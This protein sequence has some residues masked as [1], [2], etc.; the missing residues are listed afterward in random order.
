VADFTHYRIYCETEAAWVDV[1]A[2]TP[3]TTCP[4]NVAHTVRA[5]SAAQFETKLIELVPEGG[6]GLCGVAVGV[7]DETLRVAGSQL[8]TGSLYIG[9]LTTPSAPTVQQ[10]GTPGSTT[11]GYKVSALDE[12]GETLASSESQ[13][14]DGAATLNVTDYN[15]ISWSAVTGAANYKVYRS[16]AGGTPATTGKIATTQDLTLDDTG[17]SANDAEP[18]ENTTGEPSVVA[19]IVKLGASRAGDPASPGEGDLWYDP[20]GGELKFRKGAATVEARDAIKLQGYPVDTVAPTDEY[21][22]AWNDT[23]GEWQPTSLDSLPG[24]AYYDSVLAS[25]QTSTTSATY[26]LVDSMTITPPA[27]TYLVTFVTTLEHSDNGSEIYF[28]IFAGGTQV[29]S[30]EQRIVQSRWVNATIM[31]TTIGEA[32]VNGSEAIEVRWYTITSGT[33]YCNNRTLGVL[34]VS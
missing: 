25:T 30:S 2:D 19:G 10:Q 3:P 31:G 18:T 33:A 21:V 27:G 32:T 22:L 34:R 5:D 14:T 1:W 23:D 11:W 6:Q 20:T 26:V 7:A 4:N 29:V 24:S 12:N 16:T 8:S 17:L 28:S 9:I 15:T 13:I